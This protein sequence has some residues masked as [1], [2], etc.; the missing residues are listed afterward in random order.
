MNKF[1]RWGVVAAV[2]TILATLTACATRAPSDSIVLYYESGTG[3]DKKFLE[4][5][6]PGESGSYP[7]DDEVFE[8]PTSQRTWNIRADGTGDSKS[9][10][11]SGTA[12]VKADDGSTQPGAEVNIYPTADF[13]IN[14]DCGDGTRDGSGAKSPVV[15]MWE[16]SGRRDW[17]GLG[18]IAKDGLAEDDD[19]G[20]F[21]IEAFRCMLTN[22][23]VPAEE[24]AL[25]QEARKYS[26]DDLDA[27]TNDVWTTMERNLAP[28]FQQVLRDKLGGDYFCGT[29]YAY[30]RE[31]TWTE[32]RP[33]TEDGRPALDDSGQPVYKE[34]EKKG[35]CP[36]VRISIGD[37]GF[38]NKS[39]AD[40]RADVYAAEQRAKAAKID[41]QGQKER[42]DI[43]T[44]VGNSQGYL[45]LQEI[46]ADKRRSDATVEA[47]RAASDACKRAR[48]CTVIVGADGNVN[49]PAGR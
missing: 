14:T 34:V 40:A 32:F 38:K 47:A 17:C 24:K 39:I 41:A 1:T 26:A 19:G 45:R 13:F 3:D 30:G 9:P 35:T 37:V 42:A 22:T 23:L 11:S 2:L 6:K 7:V 8:I 28:T 12:Q 49:V 25:R 27:N 36:P 43:L 20:G 18:G 48:N 10:I 44:K 31:V 46:E 21:D 5:I 15:R 29:G 33:V 4:C 16:N